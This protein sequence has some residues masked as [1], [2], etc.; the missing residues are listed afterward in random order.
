MG[1]AVVERVKNWTAKLVWPDVSGEEGVSRACSIG[2]AAQAA[3]ASTYALSFVTVLDGGNLIGDAADDG[4][5]RALA[6]VSLSGATVATSYL[7]IRIWARR[8]A[9]SAWVGLLW[10]GYE[11]LNAVMGITPANPAILFILLLAAFQGVRACPFSIV[12]DK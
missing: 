7:A 6:L 4:A 9:L 11:S 10:I 3:V 2:A 5:I 12:D 1:G 8:C